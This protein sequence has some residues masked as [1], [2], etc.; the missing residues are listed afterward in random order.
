MPRPRRPRLARRTRHGWSVRP[1]TLGLE[2][3]ASSLYVACMWPGLGRRW[4][5]VTGVI[6]DVPQLSAEQLR[7]K[8]RE[9]IAPAG[10]EDPTVVL[11]LPRRDIIVRHLVLPAAAEK[12]I[13]NALNL[14][15]G[16]YKPSDEDDF[17]WDA[18]VVRGGQQL[19]VTLA[20]VPRARIEELAAKLHDAGFPVSRLTTAQFSTLDWVLRSVADRES[21]NLLL[22]QSRGLEIELTV[23]KKG[24]CVGCRSFV[25]GGD[26]AAT[27]AGEIHKLLSAHRISAAESLTVVYAG[28]DASTWRAALS[29]FGE[30][31]ELAQFCDAYSLTETRESLDEYWG[32]IA[33]AVDG[34]NWTGDYRLNLLPRELRP[35]R[36]RW[37]NV[38]TYALLAAN[39][40]LLTALAARGP[41]Q[42]QITLRRYNYEIS[43][44]ERKASLVERQLKQRDRIQ[45]HLAALRGFQEQGR[46]PLDALSDVAQKLPPDAWVSAYTFHDNKV[47]ITGTA[48]SASAILPAL[49]TVAQFEGV[50]FA[51]GLTREA[52]GGERFHIQVKLKEM[53]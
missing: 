30:P 36:R 24:S 8:L 18:A 25:G 52:G 13:G 20:F 6:E 10:A 32:A 42:R 21:L 48:K 44:V 9:L 12:S 5:S 34:L 19:S 50:E 11:G 16:L 41:I 2:L 35:T 40:L 49:K 3:R 29:Q 47:D 38:P 45:A 33:L 22:V 43:Q 51:G 39:A 26:P 7:E 4:L 17:C 28:A 14:Q 15:L 53:Q 46:R 31:V 1:A 23:V 27:L 37:Q